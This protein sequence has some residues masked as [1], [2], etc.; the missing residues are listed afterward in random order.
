MTGL[1]S[2][3]V[4][5]AVMLVLV[6]ATA[7]TALAQTVPSNG[8]PGTMRT[9]VSPAPGE[10]LDYAVWERLAAEAEGLL[11][12]ATSS[13]LSLEAQR[14]QIV[15]WRE[16][17]LAA[18]DANAQGI[19]TLRAQIEA[20]G[21]APAEGVTEAPE[22]AQRRT[23]LQARLTEAQAPAIAADEAYRRADGIIRQIDRILRERQTAELMRLWPSPVNP[24]NWPEALTSLAATFTEIGAEI[25]TNAADP[26]RRAD[27]V[28]T[29]PA[30][31]ALL[32][33]AVG[34]IWR[35][36]RSIEGFV[37]RLQAR[38]S[39]RGREVW[40]LLASLG[41]IV[42]PTLGVLL[43]SSALALTGM[44]GP[45]G[46]VLVERL[47]LAGFVIFAARWIGVQ[48]FPTLAVLPG[49]L[50]LSADH[51][52][53]GRLAATVLGVLIAV[54]I[55]RRAVMDPLL[56]PE[57]ATAV[58][59]FPGIVLTGLFLFRVGQ[60]IRRHVTE[61]TPAGEA[62]SY[63]NRLLGLIGRAALLVGA[64]GPLLAAVGYVS[65][66]IGMVYP[67]VISL[68]LVG[69]LLVTQRLVGD[70]YA[71]VTRAP[72][73]ERDALVPVLIGFALTLA[74]LPVF[75]LVW[76]A[77]W[78]DITEILTRFRE[79]FQLGQTRISPT[80]F[81]TFAVVFGIGFVVTRLL[82]G[83]LKSSILPKTSLDQGGQNAIVAGLGYAGI[84]LAGLI[85]INAAGID[86][87]GLAI[88]AGALSVGIGFGLQNIVSNF[89][90]GIILL[91]ERPVSEG[92]WIE[93]GAVQGT[94]KSISV[95]STR[96]Q[97]FDRTDVIVP[98]SD[99][100]SGQVTNWTRFNLTGRLIVKVGVGYG[101]DSRRVAQILREI[102]EAQP[103]AVLNPP[104]VVA[105]TGFGADSLDFEVR[106][107]LRD[108][109]FSLAV[110]SEINHEIIRRFRE[111]GIDIPFAQR[112][113][114]IL[115]PEVL[116]APVPPPATGAGGRRK[117]APP[118][119]PPAPPPMH[120]EPPPSED[121]DDEGDADP[122]RKES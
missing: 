101:S 11:A 32:I 7:G 115:N 18:L 112:E 14:A 47:T 109:N 76:G 122:D 92:D 49:T 121:P 22:I 108:V 44:P 86:L 105:F 13:D 52:A 45:L 111:E 103:L 116:S 9:G 51:R 36:R 25:R 31:L 63:R 16:S 67:A 12:D 26:E 42:V 68:W 56:K 6:L 110:R 94:V 60:L 61:D 33:V 97:T 82:Q 24:V 96:I 55:L 4:A 15:D 90:S 57:A 27:F 93:V 37:E 39:Q 73:G 80:D 54:D 70:L 46:E 23:D 29:L 85:G 48:M 3:G 104:P 65:A 84:L 118:P 114:R 50:R 88:V 8:G 64:L 83:A 34:L 43:L 72:E 120:R 69:V 71:L 53:Q 58:L 21:P 107:I 41:Q 98:N 81:L 20:L 74:A 89:V 99:L 79:G 59:A 87:S 1:L 117:A 2:R 38:A 95:R 5:L 10:Q 113:V 30:V 106:V 77:R 100:V 28:D 62:P 40:A 91:I 66:G 19:A 35:G 102:A 17:F 78:A 75:A 119:V